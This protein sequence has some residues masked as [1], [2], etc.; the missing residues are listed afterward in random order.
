MRCLFIL[1]LFLISACALQTPPTGGPVD[2]TAPVMINA[3]PPNKTVLFTSDRVEL[4]FDE[5]ILLEDAFNEI[6]ISPPMDPTPKFTH[7]G[8]KVIVD[9]KGI[10]LQ[11]KTTYSIFFGNSIV[12]FRAS[13]P[14]SNLNYVFSTGSHIDS[15]SVSGTLTLAKNKEVVSDV[16]VMLYDKLED[17]VILN[18]KPFYFS[19]TN[20]SGQYK[21][22]N[23]RQGTY[24]V[25]ALKDG[26]RNY[27][28]DLE[29]ELLGFPDSDIILQG[30]SNIENFDFNVFLQEPSKLYIKSVRNTQLGLI[31]II[32]SKGIRTFNLNTALYTEKDK[33]VIN[34]S[35]DTINYW[36]SDVYK[37]N[38]ELVLI[39]DNGN[40]DTINISLERIDNDSL[41]SKKNQVTI[42]QDVNSKSKIGK[43]SKQNVSIYKGLILKLIRPLVN[44]DP[45]KIKIVEDSS[46]LEL[47]ATIT[48][49]PND[50]RKLIIQGD[51]KENMQYEFIAAPMAFTDYLGTGNSKIILKFKTDNSEDYGTLNLLFKDPLSENA[52]IDL[53]NSRGAEINSFAPANIK[54]G[55]LNIGKLKGGVYKLRI[56]TDSNGNGKWDSGNLQGKIQAEEVFYYLKNLS[57]RANWDNEFEIEIK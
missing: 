2:K 14:A 13:N 56:F 10:A 54:G 40:S 21:I 16:L 4:T 27:K 26:N 30:D 42:A 20:E 48:M 31:Q 47:K 37:D 28:Y 50:K 12:D 38:A 6:V 24:R 39:P 41:G 15:L 36:Y 43:K 49:H 5:Y 45:G 52:V 33:A 23:I 9:L 46:R 55:I 3:T 35:R 19:K 51:W 32:Y 34:R 25:F 29:T 44:V 53:I 57:V 22:E 1:L 7:R 8:K 17:S 11:E 18:Q